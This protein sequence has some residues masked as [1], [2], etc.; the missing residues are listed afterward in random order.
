[1]SKYQLR[2]TTAF[3]K[4]LRRLSRQGRD[5][6]QLQIVVD[7][8]L[9]GEQLDPIF[10]DHSLTGNWKGFKDC[11]IASDWVLLYKIDAKVLVLT[12]TR[13]GSHSELEL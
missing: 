7:T 3:K 11:H 9:E 2:R 4:D 5:L 13:T 12:L 1:M 8:L 6:S 10:L